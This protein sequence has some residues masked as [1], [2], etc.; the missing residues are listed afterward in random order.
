MPGSLVVKSAADA[1]QVGFDGALPD[2]R[3]LRIPVR[4][5]ANL[6]TAGNEEVV[7][8]ALQKMLAMRIYQ[9]GRLIERRN[10]QDVLDQ[11]GLTAPQ[12]DE[13]YRLMAIANDEDRF[14]IPTTHREYAENAFDLRGESGFGFGNRGSEGITETTLFGK[15]K[16][17]QS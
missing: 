5:L 10:S 1:G 7:V 16:G 3:S 8:A 13:M 15:P 11:V 14:V 9:R 6:L 4:Y 2:V 12:I 17:M